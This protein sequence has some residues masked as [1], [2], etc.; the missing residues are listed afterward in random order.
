MLI[1]SLL[2]VLCVFGVGVPL[3]QAQS[4]PTYPIQL[5]IPGAPGDGA[6]IAARLFAEEFA[7]V[8]NVAVVP[9]NK[10]G[11][12]GAIAGDFVVK[13][14]KDGYTLLYANASSVVYSKASD[15]DAVPYDAAKDLE[16]LGYHTLF[17]TVA[18]VRADAPWKTFMELVDYSRKNP[19]KV[20]WGTMGVSTIDHVQWEMAKA[21]A[22][23]GKIAMIP[24]KGMSGK[25]TALLGGHVEVTS[26]PLAAFQEHYKAGKIRG[27]LIDH[28]VPEF[29]E[30]PTLQELGFKRGIPSPW[31]AVFAPIGIPDEARK[32]LIPA[33]EKTVRN[34]ELMSRMQKLWY[35]PGYKTPAE[36]K[37]L[38][39]EDYENA[40]ATFKQ[41][42]VTK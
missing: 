9:L 19:D 7:K 11:A 21:I 25:T 36:L 17:P 12:S 8:L 38:Q 39:A 16:P 6:D 3:S 26:F 10:P 5:I 29:P 37:A 24:F 22:G 34:P 42:G 13:G 33:I 4:Y 40:R 30:L 15:P 23:A 14:K 27:L 20:R 2:W 35:I 41:A 31:T 18:A 1:G 32:V 28:K